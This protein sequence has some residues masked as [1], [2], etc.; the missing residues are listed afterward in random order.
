MSN[1]DDLK[2]IRRSAAVERNLLQFRK[3]AAKGDDSREYK[4]RY[5]YTFDMSPD[6]RASIDALMGQGLS[7]LEAYDAATNRTP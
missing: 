5:D 6:R 4:A 3:Y 1:D 7:F 2:S